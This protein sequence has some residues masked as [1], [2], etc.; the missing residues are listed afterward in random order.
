MEQVS[1]QTASPKLDWRTIE[2][3]DDEG[4]RITNEKT[5]RAMAEA[6]AIADEWAIRIERSGMGEK[7]RRYYEGG[8]NFDSEEEN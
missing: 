6:E 1:E 4:K 5:L 8:D 7:M 2:M 3:Y